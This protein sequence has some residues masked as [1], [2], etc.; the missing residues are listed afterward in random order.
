MNA[1]Y[2][3]AQWTNDEIYDRVNHWGHGYYDKNTNGNIPYVNGE[4]IDYSNS[5]IDLYNFVTNIK[6]N[7]DNNFDLSGCIA[8]LN[9]GSYKTYSKI[10]SK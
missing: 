4:L 5:K 9:V 6:N 1:R 10:K 7:I 2:P 3:S 8:N